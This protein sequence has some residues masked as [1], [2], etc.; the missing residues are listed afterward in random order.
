M[1]EMIRSGT[2]TCCDSY[3]YESHVVQAAVD[4]GVR[5][6]AGLGFI[7]FSPPDG[8]EL[9]KKADAAEKFV[10]RWKT[11]S[12]MVTP[13]L[14]CHSPYTGATETLQLVKRIAA[15]AD[16]PFMMHLSETK[17]EV[18]IIRSRY[19]LRPVHYLDRIGIL[20]GRTSL[21]HCVWLD[22]EEINLLAGSGA[23]V[24][25]CPESN[26]KLASG[27]APTSEMLKRGIAVGLGT[28]GCAS[29]NDLDMLLELDTMAKLHKVS[30]MRP[31]AVDAATAL[32]IATTGGARVLGL[33]HLI[34]SVEPGKCADLVVLDMRK[35][36]LTPLYHLYSQI[37]YACRGNDVRD[38]V[39]DGKVVMRN[40]KLLTIDV[41]KAMDDVR[42][43]ADRV[44]GK[45]Q[46]VVDK[47]IS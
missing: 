30:T 1:A 33:Q 4:A 44:R 23:S 6:V 28:D 45:D 39:I 35:P 41:Q 34:G 3:F 27:V 22:D 11:L 47:L 19:S 14:F 26:M 46:E 17:E 42:K 40:R 18:E 24:C 15:E 36:H 13:S 21:V 38:V 20:G 2:T 31:T 12:P 8:K 10:A 43:I 25:H 5:I 7:D 16:V 32:Q 29:N 9:R 37:V